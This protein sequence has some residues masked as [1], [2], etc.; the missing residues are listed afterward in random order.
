MKST[1]NPLFQKTPVVNLAPLPLTKFWPA[2]RRRSNAA[3]VIGFFLAAIVSFKNINAQT[4]RYAGTQTELTNAITASAAGDIISITKN[5]VV[6]SQVSLSKSLTIEGNHYTISVPVTGLND[7]GQFNTSPSNFRVFQCITS[8]TKTVMNNLVIKG[9]FLNTASQ[10]GAAIDV[11][12][13]NASL[14]LN[15]CIISNGLGNGSS[16]GTVNGGGGIR[17]AG[18]LFL[19]NCFLRRNAA[20]FGGALLNE[21]T[22]IAFIEQTTMSENRATSTGGGG[23][24]IEN[25]TGGQIYFNNSTLSNNQSQI[26]GGAVN[27]NNGT[28]YFLNSSATGNVV[29]GSTSALLVGG[30]LSN[31]GGYMYIVN[32]LMA[33]NYRRSAGSNTNPT[34]FILDDLVAYAQQG[35]VHLYYSIYHAAMPPGMGTNS[36]NIQYGGSIDGSDNSIFSG[37][38]FSRINNEQG[39]TI[40]TASVYRPFL[41][42]DGVGTL[43]PTLKSGSFLSQ[44][45]NA[46]TPTRFANNGGTAVVVSYWNGS[47]YVAVNSMQIGNAGD[48]VTKDQTGAV[49]ANPPCRGAIENEVSNVY[50]LRVE[51]SANGSVSGGSSYGEVYPA[52]T[53]VTL[54][55]IPNA[56]FGFVRWDWVLGGSGIASSSNPYNLT[57]NQNITLVPVFAATSAGTYAITYVG[58]GNTDGSAPA[59]QT[60]S[61]STTIASTGTLARKGYIFTG[62]NTSMHG[63]GTAYAAGNNYTSG[64]NL[65]LY[66]QWQEVLWVGTISSDGSATGNWSPNQVPAAGASFSIAANAASDLVLPGDCTYGTISFR[67]AGRKIVLGNYNLAVEQLPEANAN[68]YVQAGGT[69]R[70]SMAIP[71]AETRIFPI[72]NSSYNPLQITNRTG[73]ADVFSVLVLNEVYENGSSGTALTGN[74]VTRTWDINKNNPNAGS[75]V[76]L[77]FSWNNGETSGT[78]TTPA[79]I[80]YSTKWTKQTGTTS[81]TSNSL[82]YTGYTGSFSP[83]AVVDANIVLP[84]TW[85]SFTAANKQNAVELNWTTAA[86]KDTKDFLVQHSINGNQWTA[87]GSVRAT[88]NNTAESRYSFLH[89]SPAKG[90][91]YYRLLQRDLNGY[92]TYSKVIEVM[93]NSTSASL[94]ILGNPVTNNELKIQLPRATRIFVYTV[95]GVLV[96]QQHMAEGIGSVPVSRLTR[97]KYFIKA[98]G[99]TESFVIE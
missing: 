49:R 51:A 5:I 39:L 19:N 69:G 4:T 35:L 42:A 93:S 95:N 21:T 55:A 86:E 67:G 45:G 3:R 6:S 15:G 61:G 10:H 73:S 54:T 63:T 44:P 1:F 62:W 91:N 2:F 53:A 85:I 28:L 97:G 64:T 76:D 99:Q 82:A 83:F 20:Q 23:G 9:G 52:G 57:V 71:S 18:K 11:A 84:L 80:H 32:S 37:G 92:E 75:G 59:T 16:S 96:L 7:Q 25:R 78:V 13:A 65:V 72:G 77:V 56:G 66:A 14:T 87:I 26:V 90:H 38:D 8:G 40:G 27:N 68:N 17:N 89:T 22:G 98:D 48:L 29:Y 81:Y 88:N 74:R 41:Y 47:A 70:L 30:A 46:G 79:L 43:G 33:H 58:N 31:N 12:D 50:M 36:N 34:G 60:Y 94:R 24:A